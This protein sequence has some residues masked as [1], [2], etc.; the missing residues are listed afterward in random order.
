MMNSY[1]LNMD[2]WLPI[3]KM[4]EDGI[5]YKTA[6]IENNNL[7]NVQYLKK[8]RN[9]FFTADGMYVYYTPTH[10]KPNSL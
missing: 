1:A 3:V 10:F 9:L 6:T 5:F 7:L 8:H 2:G 4:P